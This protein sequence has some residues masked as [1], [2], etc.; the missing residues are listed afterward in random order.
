MKQKKEIDFPF[1]FA[2]KCLYNFKANA[3]RLKILREKL[4]ELDKSMSMHGQSYEPINNNGG[5]NDNSPVA[6]RAL[7]IASLEDEISTL[8]LRTTPIADLIKDLSGAEVL[9][10]SR[11]AELMQIMNL[12]Y[13]GQNSADAVAYELNISRRKFYRNREQLVKLAIKY[14]GV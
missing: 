6:I 13:F 3:A 4:S 1:K 11:N 8:S 10:G 2:E 9:A 14:L 5:S 12:F 7:K